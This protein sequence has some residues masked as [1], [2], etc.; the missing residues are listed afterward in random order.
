MSIKNL[1]IKHRTL[2]N[3]DTDRFYY[4]CNQACE[5]TDEKA[6]LGK[7]EGVTCKNCLKQKKKV[8]LCEATE[9]KK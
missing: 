3:P 2:L 7:W 1:H 9:T 4:L 8:V 5:I 6:I